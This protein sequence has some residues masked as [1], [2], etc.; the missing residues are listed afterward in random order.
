MTVSSPFQGGHPSEAVE[1]GVPT[2]EL[3]QVALVLGGRY[4]K[5]STDDT[6]VVHSPSRGPGE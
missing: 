2:G 6:G 5:P 3:F 1:V 4:R